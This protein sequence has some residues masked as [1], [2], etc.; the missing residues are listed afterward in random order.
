MWASATSVPSRDSSRTLRSLADARTD[1]LGDDLKFDAVSDLKFFN[2][3]VK[4]GRNWCERVVYC[5]MHNTKINCF[6]IR[7]ILHCFMTGTCKRIS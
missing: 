7:I 3:S 6:T 1:R 5:V 4:D 2:G